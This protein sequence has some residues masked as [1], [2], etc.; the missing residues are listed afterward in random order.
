MKIYILSIIFL[1]FSKKNYLPL[2]GFFLFFL[3]HMKARSRNS[4]KCANTNWYFISKYK[5]SAKRILTLKILNFYVIHATYFGTFWARVAIP[6]KIS[7]EDLEE[8][9]IDL[10]VNIP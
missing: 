10:T 2:N 5:Y 8:K 4:L 9:N 7:L 1:S 6:P 3:V